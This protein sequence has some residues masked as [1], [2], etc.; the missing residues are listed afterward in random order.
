MTVMAAVALG[1]LFS[2][3]SKEMESVE[4]SSSVVQDI[5]AN[6]ET[7]F[8]TRFG[9]P[10]ENQ[11]WGFG[12]ITSGTRAV[13]ETP[14]ITEIGYT[15]N[16][17]MARANYSTWSN[18]GWRDKYYQVNGNVVSSDALIS[19]QLKAAI[20]KVIVGTEA[21]PGLI[22]EQKN[23]LTK[24]Q[25]TGYS[26]VTQG[27]PVTLTP[28]Y[29]QS[30]SG[31]MISYYYYKEGTT[32]DVKV[33]PKYTIGNMAD[34]EECKTNIFAL[35]ES[36]YSLVY[37]DENGNV[38]YN[39]PAGYVINFIVTNTDKKNN[40]TVEIND[41]DAALTSQGKYALT[42]N[43]TI[44]VGTMVN[45]INE[46]LEIR[47]GRYQQFA[48]VKSDG[49]SSTFDGGNNT[50]FTH[51]TPGN[52]VNAN[53]K[54]GSTVYYFKPKYSMQITL[55]VK[56]SKGKIM[57]V[58][59]LTDLDA[60]SGE[61]K[62]SYSNTTS[63]SQS[64]AYTINVEAN[65]YYAVYA[66]G[67][68]LGFYGFVAFGGGNVERKNFSDG[69]GP[70]DCGLHLDF[71][72]TEFWMGK[73][74]GSFKAAKERQIDGYRY[75]TGGTDE[76]GSLTPG[77]ATTY[78]FYPKQDGVLRVG[79]VLNADK[80]FYIKDLGTDQTAIEGTSLKGY[81]G[82]KLVS[83]YYG[84]YDFDVQA[85]HVYAVYA[86]GSKLGFYGCEF[87]TKNPDASTT[88]YVGNNPDFYGDGTYNVEI[89]TSAIGS[90]N[91]SPATTPHAAVFNSQ[92]TDENGK[93]VKLSL[94][95]FED[96]TDLDFNDVVFAVT[97]TVPEDPPVIIEVPDTDP[98]PEPIC[99]IIAEDL[100][101]SER[102]DF[103]FNDVVFDVCPDTKNNKTILIIRCVGG[104]L[105]LYVA[106]SKDAALDESR[107]V[108]NVC[109]IGSMSMT[110]TGW[111]NGGKIDYNKECGRIVLNGTVI[112]S[113]AEA[114]NI[115][116]T[117]VKKKETIELTA[118]IGRVPSKICVGTDYKWCPE[119]V[120]I[121]D[122]YHTGDNDL[123]FKEYVSGSL[124]NDDN[125]YKKVDLSGN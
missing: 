25:S 124:A 59:K 83:K 38:S 91:V 68:K 122:M 41:K 87:F 117:V 54:G 48:K 99:R 114:R 109:G 19:P 46:K 50:T 90:W 123:L 82:E 28:V 51:Y 27:G 3:C 92:C 5:V 95:G 80:A 24:A 43:Q 61:E 104:E 42:E 76:N 15:F 75:Y 64:L 18:S 22:P 10:A 33:L 62:Y 110:N 8:I 45:A 37:V 52:E 86:E 39:F 53:L 21:E 119:R 108:H 116:I 40:G 7:A 58:V 30:S 72:S 120:D 36:T 106:Q 6:Y 100:T 94:I 102:G 13:V 65:A 69:W 84:T 88:K 107:E 4:G 71:E 81:D 85:N 60:T 63:S 23:N 16:A 78:Y 103:D 32:P 35:N 1:G 67:S 56:L 17:Q 9:Q 2:S 121:D 55:G 89:H 97:G 20:K 77:D 125:W 79:V 115:A 47:F 96:W 105:P 49:S 66:E 73:P 29:H 31:D 112:S 11:T 26:I 70:F 14:S 98:D 44:P 101:T 93:K 118:E 12:P 74:S 57:K 113:R 111:D 34:P